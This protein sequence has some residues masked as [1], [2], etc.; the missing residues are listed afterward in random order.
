MTDHSSEITPDEVRSALREF[1]A[2]RPG[3]P[4][5]R[6]MLDGAGLD[7][8][9]WSTLAEQLGLAALGA[10]EAWGGTALGVDHLVAAGEE[11][12]A[13]LYAGPARAAAAIALSLAALDPEQ[14]P[15]DLA[16]CVHDVLAGDAVPG[17]SVLE[18]SDAA[19]EYADG[20]LSGRIAAVT[21]GTDADLVLC[22]AR[23]VAGPAA[24]LV[25]VRSAADRFLVPSA[26]GGLALAD[27]VV[28]GA[29]AVHVTRD[30]DGLDRHRHLVRLLL[31]AEQVGG[32]TGCLTGMVDYAAIR[33][34]FDQAIGSYQAIQHRCA[35]LAIDIAAARALV[36]AAAAATDSGEH[37]AARQLG[38]LARAHA[39]DVFDVA[40]DG[41]IQVS[42]GIGFTW[43]HDA[44]LFF[45]R[46]R[47]VAA[48]GG[49]AARHRDLAVEACCL[50]QLLAPV[51]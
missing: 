49:T 2:D 24:V 7:R 41:Y 44:H 42:G 45:R 51:S 25:D 23:T 21:H 9:T 5:A 29:P 32:A 4:E 26:D 11:C 10:P 31:A 46:A 27:I 30:A 12:G 20:V 40:A 18:V 38:L 1:F 8:D 36:A 22:V 14:V 6:R 16:A 43:E 39:T 15:D 35:N 3:T 28:D 48:L 13:A 47:T 19:P 50:D 34:Q 37:E 17:L 33:H